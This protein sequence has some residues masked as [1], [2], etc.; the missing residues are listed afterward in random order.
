MTLKEY[1]NSV[2]QDLTSLRSEDT[3]LYSCCDYKEHEVLLDMNECILTNLKLVLKSEKK[4]KRKL[5]L[6]KLR[7][8][9]CCGP[10]KH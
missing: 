10:I 1:I 7:K 4:R 3:C 2:K 9:G 5:K 8:T 6:K